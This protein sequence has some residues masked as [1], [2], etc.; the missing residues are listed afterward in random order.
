ADCWPGLSF[1]PSNAS[2][3]TSEP[4]AESTMQ[5][6][7]PQITQ[8][9]QRGPGR[10]QVVLWLQRSQMFIET[11]YKHDP[12]SSGAPYFGMIRKSEFISLRWSEEEPFRTR[13]FYKHWVPT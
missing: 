4:F 10:N 1:V 7:Y 3:Q 13:A 9:P 8:I 2:R 6:S 12:R 11:G 5:N